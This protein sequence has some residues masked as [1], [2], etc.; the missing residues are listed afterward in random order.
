MII[1]RLQEG[2]AN[3]GCREQDLPKANVTFATSP[4]PPYTRIETAGFAMFTYIQ[5]DIDKA[6]LSRPAHSRIRRAQSQALENRPLSRHASLA[7]VLQV[8]ARQPFPGALP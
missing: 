7:T 6:C 5:S 1:N 2:R 4:V 3:P 8:V